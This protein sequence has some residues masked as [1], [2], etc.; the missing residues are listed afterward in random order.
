MSTSEVH[1]REEQLDEV[2]AA[3]LEAVETGWAPG[4]QRLLAC[5][6]HLAEALTRFFANQDRVESVAAP[7]RPA[8]RNGPSPSAVPVTVDDAQTATVGQ[9]AGWPI[10]PGYEILKELGR[11][12]M[13][14]VY[15]ARQ[16]SC[17]RQVA[18]KMLLAAP[19]PG[20]Q[21]QRD[22]FRAEAHAAARLQHPGIV[23]LFEVGEYE[24]RPYLVMEYV[25]GG[26]LAERLDGTPL[27]PHEAAALVEKLARATH[28]AHQA[29]I[30]HRDLKPANV[31]LAGADRRTSC[32]LVPGS[33]PDK[34]GCLS[35][36]PKITDF[37]LAK[38]L[39]VAGQTVSGAIVGTPSY[40]A[41]EQAGSKGKEIGPA[42][43]VYGLGAIL[44]ELLTGR[45]PFKGPTP[46]DTALQV[47]SDEPVPPSQLQP[48][49]PRDLETICLKCLH[50]DAHKRYPTAEALAADLHRFQAGEPIQA[51]PVGIRERTLKW[52]RRRPALAALLALVVLG[53]LAGF[54]LVLWRWHVEGQLRL[55]ALQAE[56]REKA[57]RREA[58]RSLYLIH[59]ARAN[60]EWNAGSVDR[61]RDF[62]ALCPE[63][64]RGWE[65]HCLDRLCSS[66]KPF[67]LEHKG[68]VLNVCFS[69]D[70]KRLA[71]ASDDGTVWLWDAQTGQELLSL[72]GHT[73]GVFSVC[74]SPDGKRLACASGYQEEKIWK[75]E[76][77]M[78]EAQ[79]GHEILTLKG[80]TDA[81][82]SVCFSPDGKH[83]AGGGLSGTSRKVKVWD[84][85]TG[86]QLLSLQGDSQGVP[87]VCFSPDGN[88]LACASG[89]TVRLWD[90]QTGQ[91]LRSPVKAHPYVLD[92]VCFSPDGK[93]LA[94]A[95]N[96]EQGNTLRGG[97]E[98]WDLETGQEVL[99]LK[100]HTD[101]VSSV[102]FSPD[103]R[104][105]AS[106]SGGPFSPGEVKVWDAQTGQELLSLQ[107]Y[108]SG[109]SSVAFS[110]DGKRLAC[111]SWDRTVT[112]YDGTPLKES[113]VQPPQP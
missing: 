60:R 18:L 43:D 24:G 34:Q 41:P 103:G 25:A 84:A 28:V 13:G 71:S 112:V 6:P 106:A 45:P 35:Y 48:K 87:S 14:V 12:G 66:G 3:Y 21:A 86:R 89:G 95:S 30:I 61:A 5:Y 2:L 70:G 7:L 40:M 79:S 80:H 58:E 99:A 73:S 49:T 72:K 42:T 85:Q 16:L 8:S 32:Q 62:L 31:L 98:V 53:A 37:G 64:P 68:S 39:D 54:A 94:N 19:Q 76:V 63:E 91:Q 97:V 33:P 47:I 52:I 110:P 75:G 29:G 38:R 100:G 96:Y 11:G 78:W 36:E 83:L 108:V 92:S 104:H 93:R 17:D 101:A 20:P 67:T 81:V 15:L 69:P 44:Y 90:A 65:W 82:V 59:L 113:P 111:A 4:R 109:V 50:K 107:G 9:E 102:C 57:Q 56:Q 23:Q 105:I 74:F 10:I 88:R 1:E 27:P 77:K 51:R 55:D 26:S 46:L 22:R